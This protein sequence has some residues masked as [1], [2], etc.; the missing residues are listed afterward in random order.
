MA[1]GKIVKYK[2]HYKITIEGKTDTALPEEEPF[3]LSL[4]RKTLFSMVE[5]MNSRTKWNNVTIKEVKR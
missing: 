5:M 1:N 4:F 3:Y 2:K